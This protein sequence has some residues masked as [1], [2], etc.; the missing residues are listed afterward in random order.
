MRER[1]VASLS[2]DMAAAEMKMILGSDRT[3]V[4]FGNVDVSGTFWR[5]SEIPSLAYP[6]R[7][8]MKKRFR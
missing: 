3:Y 8:R 1:L 5:E 6:G 4:R 2:F 7:W